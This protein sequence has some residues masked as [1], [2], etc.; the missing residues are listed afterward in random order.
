MRRLAQ[1]DVKS[2]LHRLASQQ[3]VQSK[4]TQFLDG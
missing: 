1:G 3:T 2:H 4:V